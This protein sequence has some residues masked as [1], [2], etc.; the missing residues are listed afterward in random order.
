MA[1]LVP[2]IH[3]FAP[4]RKAWIPGSS[5]GMTVYWFEWP[6]TP[7]A[8]PKSSFWKGRQALSGIA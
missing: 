3:V 6:L 5:P 7:R 1:G 2:A 8:L 4:Q